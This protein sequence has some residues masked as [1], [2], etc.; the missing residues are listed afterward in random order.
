MVLQFFRMG[1]SLLLVCALTIALLATLAVGG[2]AAWRAL[3]PSSPEEAPAD[4]SAMAPQEE[5][6]LVELPPSL[7]PSPVVEDSFLLKLCEGQLV[8][9]TAEHTVVSV[10]SFDPTLLPSGDRLALSEGIAVSSWQ[11]LTQLLQDLTD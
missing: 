5:P 4:I 11:E 6:P 8:V 9:Y 1:L 3:A 2:V 10:L 7:P